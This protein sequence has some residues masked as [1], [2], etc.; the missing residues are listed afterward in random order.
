MVDL[1][2]GVFDRSKELKERLRSCPDAA[3]PTEAREVTAAPSPVPAGK[4]T[5]QRMKDRFAFLSGYSLAGI[6]LFVRA[7]GIQLRHGRPQYYSPDPA[8]QQK[9]AT[10]LAALQ[11]VGQ[12]PGRVVA[13]FIDELSYTRWPEPSLDW[14]AQAPEPPPVADRKGSRYQ[15][16]R[17]VGA[18][19]ATSGQVSVQQ[20][21]HIDRDV[22][23]RFVRR[24][25]RA[26]PEAERIYLIW[27]NWPVHH[28]DEVKHTL[29]LV[30]RLQVITL[31]TYA[32]WLNPIEKLWR[33]FRQEVDYLHPL[34]DDWK[35]LRER[36]QAFF[37][38]FAHGSVDL[39]RYVGLL[40]TGTLASALH[41]G[42]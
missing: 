38:Q 42:P 4:W 10:L 8:Y 5:L 3:E 14:C 6:S 29:A 16:Y 33:K 28:S 13:L 11:Q 34:A 40:G 31:P 41:A 36:V 26:Y 19:N 39:L 23:S 25:E 9:E 37:D 1:C 30:P 18:L 32:P 35:H 17:V 22:F 20:D 7:A 15:R 12:H 21:S 27:D 24:L 2:G